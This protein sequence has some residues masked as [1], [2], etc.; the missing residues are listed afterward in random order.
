MAVITMAMVW[1][2]GWMANLRFYDFFTVFY[3]YQA[4]WRVIMKEYMPLKRFMPPEGLQSGTA[5]SA[6]QRLV[7]SRN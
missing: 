1:V 6:G 3:S 7:M 5:T 4:D 2:D